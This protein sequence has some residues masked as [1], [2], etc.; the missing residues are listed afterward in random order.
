MESNSDENG[1]VVSSEAA[2][3]TRGAAS[4]EA[5]AKTKAKRDADM[6]LSFPCERV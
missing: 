3:A 1:V 5:A 2:L 6:N 4:A